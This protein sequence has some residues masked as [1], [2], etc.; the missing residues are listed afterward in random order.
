MAKPVQL[1]TSRGE[2]TQRK[3]YVPDKK[4]AERKDRRQR[5]KI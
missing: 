5:W 1:P 3:D 4:N 2:I